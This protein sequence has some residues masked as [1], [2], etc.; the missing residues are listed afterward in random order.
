M[1]ARI[2]FRREHLRSQGK[3]RMAGQ[4]W[5]Q[6]GVTVWLTNYCNKEPLTEFIN[7]AMGLREAF[8]GNRPDRP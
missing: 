1:D 3:G 2:Y 6:A 5:D 8:G 7:A 4:G